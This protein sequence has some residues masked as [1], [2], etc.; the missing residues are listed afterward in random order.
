MTMK[1]TVLRYEGRMILILAT[2]TFG[3]C[4]NIN[5]GDNIPVNQSPTADAGA[6]QNVPTGATVRERPTHL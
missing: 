6:D 2:L 3:A 1:K 4:D 5:N